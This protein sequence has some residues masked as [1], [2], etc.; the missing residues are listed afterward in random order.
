MAR[1]VVFNGMTMVHPGALSKIDV[2][3]MAQLSLGVTGVVGIIGE[4][5]GGRPNV[6]D[7][8]YIPIL[9]DS[10][11]VKDIYKS[12]PLADA[13]QTVFSPSN[14]PRIP[15]GA[16]AVR[17]VKV[18]KSTQ[19]EADIFGQLG[20]G[21]ET[22][23]Q[24]HV[25]SYDY[26]VDTTRINLFPE[27]DPINPHKYQV[28]V[29]QDAKKEVLSD[30]GA[31]PLMN[32][33]FKGPEEPIIQY[34]G[35]TE[36]GT[37]QDI[38]VDSNLPA[39]G[40]LPGMY[41]YIPPA[42]GTQLCEGEWRRIVN[43]IAGTSVEVINELLPIPVPGF[44]S[45]PTT[46][47]RYIIV[48]SMIFKG[49]TVNVVDASLANPQITIGGEAELP[50]SQRIT[51]ILAG[52]NVFD[53]LYLRVM[54]GDSA[55]LIRKIDSITFTPG[56]DITLI[57]CANNNFTQTLFLDG[58]E[59]AIIDIKSALGVMTGALGASTRLRTFITWGTSM[60][61][62]QYTTTA[63]GTPTTVEVAPATFTIDAQI[64]NRVKIL[65][66]GGVAPEGESSYITDNDADTLTVS[67]AFT[68]A[69]PLGATFLIED[70]DLDL[71]L[72]T[73]KSVKNLVT[74][75]V[76]TYAESSQPTAG[77]N[78]AAYVG[79][80]RNGSLASTLFDFDSRNY[81][82]DIAADRDFEPYDKA[83]LLDDLNILITEINNR[84]GLIL[85]ERSTEEIADTTK[86]GA[87]FPALFTEDSPV[88]L[89]GGIRGTSL[90]SDWQQAF[91]DLIKERVNIVIPLISQNLAEEGNGS[92]AELLSVIQM[93][94]EHVWL[95]RG[96]AKS[97]RIGY[98]SCYK[99]GTGALK[100]I[101]D[102]SGKIDDE[103]V[104]LSF[105]SP[106]VLD[107]DSTLTKLPPW[108][109]SC[110][111]AG[112][113]AGS[114][115]GTALTFKYAKASEV[116]NNSPE[117]DVLDK[118]VSNQLLLAGVLFTEKVEGRGH[119]WVRHLS[120]YAGVDNLA[121]TDLNVNEIVKYIAYEA[122]TYIENQFTGLMA[123][124]TLIG[125]VKA[126]LSSLLEVYRND[127][128]IVDGNDPVTGAPRYAYS[129]AKCTLTGDILNIEYKIIPAT[130]INYELLSMKVGI[131][132]IS[133]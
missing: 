90:N 41:V 128:L 8:K 58:D 74:E 54:S 44:S 6:A 92:D 109:H 123:S 18:N 104:G 101:L 89:T 13:I 2:S 126:A 60:G 118:S 110:I 87:G 52:T 130:S 68:A 46:G 88:W 77:S 95:A 34:E 108:A 81:D 105:Q 25:K 53:D 51:E 84:S 97:E 45:A 111:A 103:D 93:L 21:C 65:T 14:D 33:T 99:T 98:A 91:N 119:R 83:R 37:T 22:E 112:M 57:L 70:V 1:F 23:H 67:P 114:P 82:V 48:K 17:P 75:I 86:V 49:P 121:K 73:T 30:L 125:A 55:G 24:V 71:Q 39:S 94:K 38:I 78:Y 26:G 80:G 47:T 127:G 42:D 96:I 3:E 27:V 132:I 102:M 76:S 50:G 20:Y 9:Y 36:A 79:Y 35:L 133:A 72:A 4:A 115:I 40:I 5:D 10:S 15:S 16:F 124:R 85:M 117:C 12:G 129:I 120:T 19:S 62:T 122:R 64:G 66:A 11:Q 32:L 63:L 107:I 7:S 43:F 56:G 116:D 106:T 28:T 59:V 61:G 113:Q 31:Q 131:P 69:V 29:R 100:Y